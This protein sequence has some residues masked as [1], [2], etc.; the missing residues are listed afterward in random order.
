MQCAEY[1]LLSRAF[2]YVTRSYILMSSLM[3]TTPRAEESLKPNFKSLV[4]DQSLIQQRS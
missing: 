2:K 3:A 1:D 4:S